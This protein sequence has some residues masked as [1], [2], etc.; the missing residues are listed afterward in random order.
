MELS[1]VSSKGRWNPTCPVSHCHSRRRLVHY[2]TVVSLGQEGVV[3]FFSKDVHK[4]T[5]RLVSP[6]FIQQTKSQSSLG[7]FYTIHPLIP[8]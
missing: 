4:K 7:I 3:L 1:V 5:K 8:V 6:S 2:L